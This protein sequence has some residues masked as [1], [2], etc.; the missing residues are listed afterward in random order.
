VPET[1]LRAILG[2]NFIRFLGL[3]RTKLAAIAARIGPSYDQI[4]GPGPELD[5]ALLDHLNLRSG[6]L[7]PAEGEKR[8]GDMQALLK[9]DLGR[10]SPSGQLL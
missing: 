8:V 4:A 10:M 3:D 7:E 6:Y 9:S 5:P 2:E 1:E